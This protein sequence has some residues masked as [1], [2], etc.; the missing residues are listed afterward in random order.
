L[1]GAGVGGGA[2]VRKY[3]DY[4]AIDNLRNIDVPPES[5]SL[6]LPHIT[7]MSQEAAALGLSAEQQENF[8]DV[9][10]L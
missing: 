7:K 3:F 5:K 6:T 1:G 9:S 2:R 10:L 4:T 8:E